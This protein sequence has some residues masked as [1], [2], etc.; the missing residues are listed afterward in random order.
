MRTRHDRERQ[1]PKSVPYQAM[2]DF[3]IEVFHADG[4][5]TASLGLTWEAL[6]DRIHG[7]LPGMTRLLKVAYHCFAKNRLRLN[8][9][10]AHGACELHTKPR[11]LSASR[12]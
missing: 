10:C 11:A 12:L 4:S 9:R 7:R 1:G 2:A 6:M 3:E 8:G 5:D